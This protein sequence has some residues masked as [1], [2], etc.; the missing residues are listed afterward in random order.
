MRKQ[1]RSSMLFLVC[2][3][4]MTTRLRAGPKSQ[5]RLELINGGR[6]IREDPSEVRKAARRGRVI[7]M[8][9]RQE[10]PEP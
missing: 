7:P 1:T 2:V 5:R 9:Q 3:V 4:D 8:P 10:G 6:P